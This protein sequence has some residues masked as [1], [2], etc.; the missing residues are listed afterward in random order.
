MKQGNNISAIWAAGAALLLLFMA[1][2]CGPDA[3][4]DGTAL[5]PSA[6]ASPGQETTRGDAS[7]T[8]APAGTPTG[9]LGTGGREIRLT[10]ALPPAVERLPLSEPSPVTG[11]VRQDLLDAILEDAKARTGIEAGDLELVRAEAVIWNDGSLGCPQPDVT[12]TQA[13]VDG[14]WVVLQVT[15]EEL[16]YRAAQTGFFFLCEQSLRSP[17]DAAPPTPEE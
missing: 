1:I 8:V 3:A 10:P 17:S 16:D 13:P 5:P 4:V 2:A 15:G 14:Y 11:E 9:E 7:P 12:Y 6:T